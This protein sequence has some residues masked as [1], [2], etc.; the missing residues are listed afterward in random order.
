MGGKTG[1]RA[2]TVPAGGSAGGRRPL[3]TAANSKTVPHGAHQV[4]DGP[5]FH[6]VKAELRG[7]PVMGLAR[8]HEPVVGCGPHRRCRP[9]QQQREQGQQRGPGAGLPENA[10]DDQ[11]AEQD[12]PDRQLGNL[13]RQLSAQIKRVHGDQSSGPGCVMERRVQP[14][15]GVPTARYSTPG[16]ASGG[17]RR[18]PLASMINA[19]RIVRSSFGQSACWICGHSVATTAASASATVS[20]RSAESAAPARFG[21]RALDGGIVAAHLRSGRQQLDGQFHRPAAAQGVRAGLVRQA[22]HGNGPAGQRA[23][24]RP[25]TAQRPVFVGV[26]AREDGGKDRRVFP[27]FPGQVA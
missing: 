13:L 2:E 19:R 8:L 7:R 15:A 5:D 27:P 3:N 4:E 25:H 26:V 9:E 21:G 1:E 22:Q 20:P 17:R 10:G 12:E 18:N 16:A 11:P 14:R 24:Q 23:E 6:E